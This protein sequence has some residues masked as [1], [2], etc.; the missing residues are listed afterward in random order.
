MKLNDKLLLG[1][2]ENQSVLI[3]RYVKN[4]LRNC[5]LKYTARQWLAESIKNKWL[6]IILWWGESWVHHQDVIVKLLIQLVMEIL[7]SSGKR[8]G[9]SQGISETSGCVEAVATMIR[10]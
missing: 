1:F 5:Q 8:S 4:E 3:A 6:K 10:S 9:R 2:Q 7:H